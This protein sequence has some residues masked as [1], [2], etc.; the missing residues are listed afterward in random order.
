MKQRP[1]KKPI[2]RTECTVDKQLLTNILDQLD[3]QRDLINRL[4]T[5]LSMSEEALA[6]MT[7]RYN[8]LYLLA[9]TPVITLERTGRISDYNNDAAI[10]LGEVTTL[11]GRPFV[12]FMSRESI[13]VFRRQLVHCITAANP[14]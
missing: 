12:S 9:R 3:T 5:K 11:K 4:K 10:F 2:T 13:G 6:G 1:S 8:G 14:V 7:A